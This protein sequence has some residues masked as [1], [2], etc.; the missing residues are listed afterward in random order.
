LGVSRCIYAVLSPCGWALAAWLPS[1]LQADRCWLRPGVVITNK[2][3]L[4]NGLP[5][6]R[7]SLATIANWCIR[8]PRWRDP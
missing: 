7:F 1:R 6:K 5:G 8:Q 2:A 3:K 4:I